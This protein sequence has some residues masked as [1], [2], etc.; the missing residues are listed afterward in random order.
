MK[1][2][3]VLLSAEKGSFYRRG[4]VRKRADFEGG[5]KKGRRMAKDEE[6]S[7]SPL[8]DRT[9]CGGIYEP[10]KLRQLLARRKTR[11]RERNARNEHRLLL[12][13]VSSVLN[14]LRSRLNNHDRRFV[15]QRE[16]SDLEGKSSQFHRATR[17]R[18]KKREKRKR[19]SGSPPHS[20]VRSTVSQYRP[21]SSVDIGFSGSRVLGRKGRKSSGWARMYEAAW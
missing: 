6:E 16:C 10:S 8:R 1:V 7:D 17:R 12:R 13:Q 19:T 4:E 15:V 14:R 9:S 3:Y 18:A 11:E 5:G 2:L 20:A 21:Y